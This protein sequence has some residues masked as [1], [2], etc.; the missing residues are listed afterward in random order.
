MKR[1]LVNAALV[2]ALVS[3]GGVAAVAWGSGAGTAHAA[4]SVSQQ[5]EARWAV[6]WISDPNVTRLQNDIQAAQSIPD[7]DTTALEHA[8]A[9][10][11]ADVQA[12]RDHAPDS[13]F[14][15]KDLDKTLADTE[16]A[17]KAL[18]HGD[19]NGANK[20]GA[21]AQK[22]EAAFEKK[23]SDKFPASA[24]RAGQTKKAP[25]APDPWV[26]GQIDWAKAHG[27]L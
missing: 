17:C 25:G 14:D 26:Q 10:L 6:K 4:T 16:A 20:L 22:D 8:S 21:A 19:I 15:N 13:P 2:A 1:R 23:L 5:D 3:G 11:A 27:L 7:T 18:S 24:P 12:V 9:H